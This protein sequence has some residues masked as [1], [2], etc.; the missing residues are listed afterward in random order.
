MSEDKVA[1]GKKT[2]VT[3]EIAIFQMK[4]TDKG[5]VITLADTRPPVGMTKTAQVKAW[6]LENLSGEKDVTFVAARVL[7][8]GVIEEKPG[9]PIRRFV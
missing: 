7:I 3:R 6:M 8:S 2:R 9:K 1:Y 5:V 4:S